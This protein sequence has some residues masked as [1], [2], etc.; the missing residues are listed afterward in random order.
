VVLDAALAIEACR[1]RED[2]GAVGVERRY[3]AA[4]VR[5]AEYR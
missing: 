3:R 5:N 1:D 2:R 4:R